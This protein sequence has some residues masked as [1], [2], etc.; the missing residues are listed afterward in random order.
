MAPEPGHRACD[1]DREAVSA[2]LREAAGEGR[3]SLGEVDE[4]LDAVWKARTYGEL[5]VLTG[6]LPDLVDL[7]APLGLPDRGLQRPVARPA[8]GATV[9]APGAARRA[10]TIVAVFSSHDTRGPWR[11]PSTLNAVA[12]FGGIALDLRAA[13]LTAAET[14]VHA[15]AVFGTVEIVVP[16]DVEVRVDGIG[17]FGG[18]Q[19]SGATAPDTPRDAPVLRVT[20]ASLFGG[21]QVTSRPRVAL[22]RDGDRDGAGRPG[23]DRGPAAVLGR[24][25]PR[26]PSIAPDVTDAGQGRL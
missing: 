10:D 20:G 5:A 9:V 12:V 21:V 23:A 17:Q 26:P 8:G 6:D 3:L 7:P 16:D 18:F 24:E 19:H 1:A 13:V 11:V 25:D 4:R 14:T 2:V 22:D 15:L